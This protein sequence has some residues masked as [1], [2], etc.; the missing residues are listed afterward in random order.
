LLC[1]EAPGANNRVTMTIS[2]AAL[3][4]AKNLLQFMMVLLI[5]QIE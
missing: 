5:L 3:A 2:R 4:A 1:A